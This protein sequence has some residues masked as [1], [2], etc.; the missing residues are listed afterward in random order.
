MGK[1]MRGTMFGVSSPNHDEPIKVGTLN[2]DGV[3]VNLAVYP[4]KVSQRGRKFDP[5]KLSYPL[6]SKRIL[7]AVPVRRHHIS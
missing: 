6:G 5:I 3:E 1:N 2:I 7:K 4:E